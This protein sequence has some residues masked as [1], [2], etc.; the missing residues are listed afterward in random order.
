[1]RKTHHK[2][3]AAG[4]AQGEGPE[5]KPQLPPHPKKE[6]KK[7]KSRGEGKQSGHFMSMKPEW[8]AHHRQSSKEN[9]NAERNLT[10]L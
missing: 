3:R 9:K 7:K 1:L 4:V 6:E 5:F 8:D 10:L 2:N